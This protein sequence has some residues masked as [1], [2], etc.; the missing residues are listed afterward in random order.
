MAGPDKAG[1][2]GV[3][4]IVWI[5]VIYDIYTSYYSD[6]R[7]YI[8]G[9]WIMSSKDIVHNKY[10]NILCA[11]LRTNNI[12]KHHYYPSSSSITKNGHIITRDEFE[13]YEYN[14]DCID[15]QQI[16]YYYPQLSNIDGK[17]SIYTGSDTYRNIISN[18]SG[19][20][21]YKIK[22][23]P[24]YSLCIDVAYDKYIIN[25]N[26]YVRL[27]KEFCI[28]Y[29]GA[30]YITFNKSNDPNKDHFIIYNNSK[31]NDKQLFINTQMKNKL[32]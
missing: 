18:V 26:I 12:L 25:E 27:V 13:L 2:I 22:Y 20:E 15:L 10:Y 29:I 31:I 16:S 17:F 4:I 7:N 21:E 6:A 23:F 11:D 30:N 3:I 14:R 9:P 5:Y 19:L 28:T 8:G 24:H 1:V 32:Y